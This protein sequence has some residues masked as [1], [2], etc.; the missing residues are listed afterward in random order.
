MLLQLPYQ[1][2][3]A[4]ENL[5]HPNTGGQWAIDCYNVEPSKF[6]RLRAIICAHTYNA[7]T[8]ET[9]YGNVGLI[10]AQ[11]PDDWS[12]ISNRMSDEIIMDGLGS[13]EKYTRPLD[14]L[15]P[16]KNIDITIH[17]HSNSIRPEIK[18]TSLYIDTLLNGGQLTLITAKQA[19]Q[20]IYPGNN[21]E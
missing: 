12:D 6:R 9:K 2:E 15:K 1:Q 10:H 4:L 20:M 18:H 16:V 7:I 19:F 11:S 21:Y 14:E 13:L 3:I 17:G 8:L 5:S